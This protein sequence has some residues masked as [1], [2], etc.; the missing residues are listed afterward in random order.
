[1]RLAHIIHGLKE[2]LY[3]VDHL[4]IGAEQTARAMR[5][6]ADDEAEERRERLNKERKDR[7]QR[8][9]K[10]RRRKS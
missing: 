8:N 4:R 9:S 5:G 2:T 1:M 3:L 7:K 10:R 6:E